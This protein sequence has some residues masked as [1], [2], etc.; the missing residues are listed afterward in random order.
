MNEGLRLSWLAPTRHRYV[1]TCDGRPIASAQTL[2]GARAYLLLAT[3]VHADQLCFMAAWHHTDTS[4]T[5]VREVS[6]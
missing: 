6:A 2:D 1:I 3:R 4:T 5:P